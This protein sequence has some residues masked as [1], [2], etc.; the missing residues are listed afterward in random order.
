MPE[1][2]L[3]TLERREGWA[4]IAINRPER[5]NSIIPPVSVGIGDALDELA[6][7]NDIAS[8]LLRGEG[9]YFC[10]G[11]DLKALQATPPPPWRG[12]HSTSWRDL[13]LKLFSF[14]KPVVGAFESYGINAGAALA[15]ACDI[16]ITGETA[17]LQVGEVQ[18]G[19]MAPMNMA[20]LRIKTT[21]QVL[22]RLAFYGDRI[23]GP[24]LLRLGLAAE[25]VADDQVLARCREVCQR[26]AGF[27]SGAT[28]SIKRGII[29][30]RGIED[31]QAYFRQPTSNALLGAKMVE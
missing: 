9:G 19:A 28:A 23:A 1:Q 30:Q 20:W 26:F 6:D 31:P 2:D 24:E 14:P 18:Q 17:F 5:R 7:D 12:E 16:L 8:V 11:I 27:P 10:S 22:A 21:E 25:C 13:H 4:E 3:V 29:E 15:M